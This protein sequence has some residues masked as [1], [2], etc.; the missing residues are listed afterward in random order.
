MA[1]TRKL[2]CHLTEEDLLDRGKQLANSE[3]DYTVVEIQ[4]KAAA[5]EFKR[6]LDAINSRIQELSTAI[7]DKIELRDVEC[8]ICSNFQTMQKEVVRADTGETVETYE[9]SE[10]E[11]Q[12]KLL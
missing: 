9:M 3:H 2:P 5:D 12:G 8:T 11:R 1:I 4:K 10:S 6:S 7:R